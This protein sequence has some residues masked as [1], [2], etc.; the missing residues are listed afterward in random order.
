MCL[1]CISKWGRIRK[2]TLLCIVV[3][4]LV[5]AQHVFRSC[6][7]I[8]PGV[9]LVRLVQKKMRFTVLLCLG[10]VSD[11][12]TGGGGS[13]RCPQGVISRKRSYN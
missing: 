5:V 10:N 4:W 11:V 1:Q 9:T 2:N 6:N 12:D 13:N 7:L 8:P 3:M